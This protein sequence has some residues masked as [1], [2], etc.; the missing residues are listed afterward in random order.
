VCVVFWRRTSFCCPCVGC[1]GDKF[2]LFRTLWWPD[3]KK[4]LRPLSD[5]PS[6]LKTKHV[7]PRFQ[8]SS[9]CNT[10]QTRGYQRHRVPITPWRGSRMGFRSRNGKDLAP[11]LSQKGATL[12]TL[13]ISISMFV[14][15]MVFSTVQ[16]VL[17]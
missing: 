10:L 6:V 8:C 2:I 15:K 16:P 9:N 4:S 13:F 17:T 5:R 1:Q 7:E 12:S 11:G 3:A 14:L